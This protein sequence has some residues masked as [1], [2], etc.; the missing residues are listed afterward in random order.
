MA[1]GQR[2]IQKLGPWK[3][4][5]LDPGLSA[6]RF[7]RKFLLI[8]PVYGT[9]YGSPEDSEVAWGHQEVRDSE[10]T[11]T[12]QPH[13]WVKLPRALLRRAKVV[14]FIP[15][16]LDRYLLEE[17]KKIKCVCV[18]GECMLLPGLHLKSQA[19]YFKTRQEVTVEDCSCSEAVAL[20]NV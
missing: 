2:A 20:A 15:R 12:I 19:V 11:A 3:K 4:P 14:C 5:D 10:G 13:Q 9:F 1:A 8:H 7:L 17:V 18:G 16:Y 6:S